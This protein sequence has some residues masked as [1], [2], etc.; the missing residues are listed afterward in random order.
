V[1]SRIGT[2]SQKEA[3]VIVRPDD[4]EMALKEAA[5]NE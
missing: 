4:L 5:L 2:P 1:A 3:P